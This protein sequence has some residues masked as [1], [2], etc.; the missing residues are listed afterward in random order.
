MYAVAAHQLHRASAGFISSFSWVLSSPFAQRPAPSVYNLQPICYALYHK[1]GLMARLFLFLDDP[2]Q[3]L[4]HAHVGSSPILGGHC[5]YPIFYPSVYNL[6]APC[7][8]RS[9]MARAFLFL[10]D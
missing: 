2:V 1:R 10:S 7:H 9:L 6:Y 5:P 4:A 3:S 8:K